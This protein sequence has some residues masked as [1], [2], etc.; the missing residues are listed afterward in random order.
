LAPIHSVALV[1]R[2]MQQESARN[3]NEISAFHPELIFREV[4]GCHRSSEIVFF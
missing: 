2:G 4:P 1:W 3:P